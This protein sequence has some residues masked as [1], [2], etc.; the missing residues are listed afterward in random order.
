MRT[1]IAPTWQQIGQ[2]VAIA[3]IRTGLNY[4]LNKDVQERRDEVA[5]KE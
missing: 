5:A 4:F 3:A 1:A 2:L